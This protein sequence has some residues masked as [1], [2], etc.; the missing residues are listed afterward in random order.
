MTS[1][2]LG[3]QEFD[4]YPL[5]LVWAQMEALVDEGL[6]KSIGISNWTVA[7]LNDMLGYARI[8]PVVN[9]FEIH[10]YNNRKEL[11]EFCQLHNI[12]PVAYRVIY[13]PP[14]HPLYPFQKP[15]LNEPIIL[16]LAQKYNKT[17]AQIL[18]QWCLMRKCGL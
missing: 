10:P 18:L 15:I 7:L 11:V 12:I 16:E 4:R 6:V 8:L 9:Q 1:L 17:P 13:K 5:H 2:Q 14:E 3:R